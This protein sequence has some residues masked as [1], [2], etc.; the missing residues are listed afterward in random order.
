MASPLRTRK[1]LSSGEVVEDRLRTGGWLGRP[2]GITAEPVKDLLAKRWK[3]LDPPLSR[4]RDLLLDSQPAAVVRAFNSTFV[5]LVR[6][7][8]EPY[9]MHYY[10][11]A[12]SSAADVRKS[13]R[14]RGIRPGP[15]L[16]KFLTAFDGLR[17]QRLP[18]LGGFVPHGE[19]TA[20]NRG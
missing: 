16:V 19:W 6:A 17:D 11:P 15:L 10:V 12:P 3:K 7:L 9:E 20:V 1:L 13:L 4:L 14:A 8:D 18:V 2:S 5:E